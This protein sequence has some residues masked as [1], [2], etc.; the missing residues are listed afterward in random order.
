MG[1]LSW[2][3]YSSLF[4]PH[5]LFMVILDE[6]LVFSGDVGF[7]SEIHGDVTYELPTLYELS[8]W[9]AYSLL[10]TYGWLYV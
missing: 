6:C 5:D 9:M 3:V 7:L 2:V 4:Y 1:G 10:N 8:V